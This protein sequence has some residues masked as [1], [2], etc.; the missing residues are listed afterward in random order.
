MLLDPEAA[1]GTNETLLEDLYGLTPRE[2]ELALLLMAGLTLEEAARGLRVTTNTVRTL[3]KRVTAKTDS[4]SQA[5]LYVVCMLC[6]PFEGWSTLKFRVVS[7]EFRR[8]S[9]HSD[10]RDILAGREDRQMCLAS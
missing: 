10:L 4:R 9:D 1:P 5:D 7:L 3:L 2:A 8:A 6:P